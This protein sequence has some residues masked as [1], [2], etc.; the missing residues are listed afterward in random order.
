LGIRRP[1]DEV[2]P[3][4]DDGATLFYQRGPK[5]RPDGVVADRVRKARFGQI[6]RHRSSA[7][8]SRKLERKPWTVIGTPRRRSI[9]DIAIVL[10]GL[11]IVAT[12]TRPHHVQVENLVLDESAERSWVTAIPLILGAQRIGERQQGHGS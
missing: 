1:G 7:A 8:H 4:G 5:I 3:C 6:E 11:R 9:I 10:R 12:S 2:R